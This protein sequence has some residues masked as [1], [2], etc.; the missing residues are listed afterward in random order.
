MVKDKEKLFSYC[1][2]EGEGS[3]HN[4]SNNHG[5]IKDQPIAEIKSK[6]IFL[7]NKHFNQF[8]YFCFTVFVLYNTSRKTNRFV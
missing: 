5:S 4:A 3:H 6:I 7:N 8:C 2:E 1:H